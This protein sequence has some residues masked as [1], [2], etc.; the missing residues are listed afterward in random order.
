MGRLLEYGKRFLA[1]NGSPEQID[2]LVQRLNDQAILA[3]SQDIQT[4]ETPLLDDVQTRRDLFNIWQAYRNNTI[5]RPLEEAGFRRLINKYLGSEKTGNIDGIFNP[6]ERAVRQYYSVFDGHFGKN[7]KIDDQIL[8]LDTGEQGDVNP[9]VRKYIYR[10]WNN[11]KIKDWA[12]LLTDRTGTLGNCGLRIGVVNN[13]VVMGIE[14]PSIIK[15]IEENSLGEIEQIVLEYDQWEGEFEAQG[16]EVPRTKHKYI[17]YMSRTKFWMTRD[18]QWYNPVTKE[19]FKTKEECIRPNSLGVVPYRIVTQNKTGSPWGLPCFIGNERK[20]DKVNALTAHLFTQIKRHI[21]VTWLVEAGGP[22]PKKVNMG[23]M[24]IWYVQKDSMGSGAKA[25][26]LVLNLNLQS[27]IA[28]R[29]KTMEEIMNSMPELKSTDGQFLSHQSGSG[30]SNLR[31]PSEQRILDARDSIESDMIEA[32]KIACAVGIA[33]GQLKINKKSGVVAAKKALEDG[34][35]N[36]QF[37]ER[38]A[39]PISVSDKLTMAKASAIESGRS[40]GVGL[41]GGNNIPVSS[42]GS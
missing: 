29:D 37:N 39:L 22:E 13:Q 31:L 8:N 32:Q 11:S 5:Y 10:V 26:P 18:G 35:L 9:D 42:S 28:E 23:D 7:I 15:S 3:A 16:T 30:V 19:K 40:A 36:H 38:E 12:S 34:T 33:L 21:T 2:A 6:V 4:S 41:N 14:H 1:P 25:T 17:E 24:T 27:C 20:I